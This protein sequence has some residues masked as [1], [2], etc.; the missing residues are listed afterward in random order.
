M[1]RQ[2]G[3]ALIEIAIVLLLTGLLLSGFLIGQELITSSRVL[4][5]IAQQDK[6]RAA[7][8]GFVDRFHA[9]P[10]DYRAAT[11][12]IPGV[13][14]CGGNGNG[15]GRIEGPS[16][17]PPS[18]ESVLVW[19][20]LSKSGFLDGSYTC[21][22][23]ESNTT[24]PTNPFGP[25]RQL[26][27]DSKYADSGPGTPQARHSLKTGNLIPSNVLAEIDRKTDDGKATSGAF[28][29]SDYDGGG[30]APRPQDCYDQTGGH[31][32]KS[33]DPEVNCGATTLF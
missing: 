6:M 3:F 31:G 22:P 33:V 17:I 25:R 9:L 7:Y 4:N 20:H 2:A 30:G 15:N 32:W 21:D 12:T 14:G 13:T 10:G 29:F 23:T 19:E 11:T 27:W 26:T 5:L 24:T 1:T 8:V 18:N 16:A 28:R